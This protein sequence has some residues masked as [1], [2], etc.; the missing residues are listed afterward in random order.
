MDLNAVVQQAKQAGIADDHAPIQPV[1][2]RMPEQKEDFG[3]KIRGLLNDIPTVIA[4]ISSN[5]NTQAAKKH[6]Q[7]NETFFCH[8][9]PGR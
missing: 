8:G 6:G 7:E 4:Q 9:K 5:I 3:K 1:L 2:K